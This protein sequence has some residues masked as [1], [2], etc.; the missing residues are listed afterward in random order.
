MVN[1]I[2]EIEGEIKRVQKIKEDYQRAAAVSL[3]VMQAHL[4][5]EGIQLCDEVLA[6][7]AGQLGGTE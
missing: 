4:A 3:S 7:L 2:S 6:R 1:N 5:N